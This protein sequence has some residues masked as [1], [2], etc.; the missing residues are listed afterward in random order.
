MKNLTKYKKQILMAMLLISG[1]LFAVLGQNLKVQGGGACI[2]WGIAVLVAV[3]INREKQL[4]E[5]EVFDI[6][7]NEVLADIALNGEK[8]E[9]FQFYNIDIVNNLRKKM[10]KKQQRQTVSCAILGVVLIITAI[11]CIV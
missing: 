2:T 11:V 9:Y 1:A 4:D 3:W 7:A 8:S 5:L 6:E 10:V